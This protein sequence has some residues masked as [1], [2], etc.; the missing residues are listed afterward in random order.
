MWVRLPPRAP[1]FVF[2]FHLVDALLP[3]LYLI[4]TCHLRSD[5]RIIGPCALHVGL[6][7]L[8]P[9]ANPRAVMFFCD[10]H[11][12]MAEQNRDAPPAP[13]NA[14]MSL[15][16]PACG[17]RIMSSKRTD[18]NDGDGVRRVAIPLISRLIPSGPSRALL[19]LIAMTIHRTWAKKRAKSIALAESTTVEWNQDWARTS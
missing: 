7:L 2:C 6:K 11:A 14:K 10:A 18:L 19:L 17:L 3:E 1:L 15:A 9:R 13:S 8:L 5:D 16:R 4:C 12:L